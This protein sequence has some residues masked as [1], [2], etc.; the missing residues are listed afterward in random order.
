MTRIFLRRLTSTWEPIMFPIPETEKSV[1]PTPLLLSSDKNLIMNKILQLTHNCHGQK[2]DFEKYKK[3]IETL[4]RD[5][6]NM[7]EE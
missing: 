7:E 6:L 2:D 3:E 5:N 4:I 1:P